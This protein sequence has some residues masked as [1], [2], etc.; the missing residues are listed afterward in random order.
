MD[1][2]LDCNLF[3]CPETRFVHPETRGWR[4]C[5]YDKCDGEKLSPTRLFTLI[6]F[7]P[8]CSYFYHYFTVKVSNIAI[9]LN[10]GKWNIIH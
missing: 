3:V 10:Q 2:Y 5:T 8:V 4:P 6:L 7:P 1:V 9:S